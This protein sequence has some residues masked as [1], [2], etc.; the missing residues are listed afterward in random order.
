MTKAAQVERRILPDPESAAR[1]V[2]DWLLERALAVEERPAF[3]LAGGTTPRQVYTMLAETPF[4]ERF[5]WRRVHWF[6]GDERM[7]PPDS[8]RSNYRMVREALFARAPIPEENI[9][10]VPTELGNAG[11]AASAYEAVLKRFYGSEHLAADR[12]LFAATLLGLGEDGHTA[13]LFPGNAALDEGR[14][15]AVGVV[16]RSVP[17]PRVTLTFPALES[18]G[19]AGFLVTG[20]AKREIVARLAHNDGLPAGRIRPAGRLLWFLDR[21]AAGNGIR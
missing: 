1:A 6:F 17:E 9:H 4:K 12:A 15:W 18:S 13:S 20:A 11:E 3:C 7:V 2:A 14:R 5:P 21:A 8:E 10:R 16:D 19:E